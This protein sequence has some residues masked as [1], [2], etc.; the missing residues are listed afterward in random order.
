VFKDEDGPEDSARG[1]YSN[2]PIAGDRS[3]FL[4]ADF[5]SNRYGWGRMKFVIDDSIFTVGRSYTVRLGFAEIFTRLCGEG[6]RVMSI[7]VGGNEVESAL[8]V[9]SR[10]GCETAL[11]LEKEIIYTG[12]DFVIELL[13]IKNN[14]MISIVDILEGEPLP[15]TVAPTTAAPTTAT[16]T[17]SPVTRVP[18]PPGNFDC[19]PTQGT[20]A[21]TREEL[22]SDLD[23]ASPYD[24]VAIC[25]GATIDTS[26]QSIAISQSFLTMCC[27]GGSDCIMANDGSGRNMVVNDA[28]TIVGIEFVGGTALRYSNKHG[29]NVQWTSSN[30]EGNHSI[31]NCTFRNGAGSY[32]GNLHISTDAAKLTIQKSTFLGGRAYGYGGGIFIA[33]GTE[34]ISIQDCEFT[35]NASGTRSGLSG[36]GLQIAAKFGQMPKLEILGTVFNDN[37]GG[38][39]STIGH[40]GDVVFSGNSGNGNTANKTWS[41]CTGFYYDTV[42]CFSLSEEWP[43]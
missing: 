10:V 19:A 31:I 18:T 2:V 7:T 22:Q 27:A 40:F 37:K 26:S 39:A 20:C 8:D 3:G 15:P 29:G 12:G 30:E 28:M 5:K 16:P 43:Q 24:T 21:S 34:N 9:Y 6:K 35:D 13:G 42:G 11:V 32:G 1:Y 25:S 36:G 23:S 4:E 14:P 38:A 33:D 41:A 17:R